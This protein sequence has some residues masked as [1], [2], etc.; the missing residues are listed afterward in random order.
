MKLFVWDNVLREQSSGIAFA[1]ADTVEEA[2]RLIIQKQ[3]KDD[4]YKSK[5]L[6]LDLL[7]KPLIIDKKE[8]FYL[9]GT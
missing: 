2:R 8:G 9:W 7:E 4:G 6:A 5:T 3:E 1:L